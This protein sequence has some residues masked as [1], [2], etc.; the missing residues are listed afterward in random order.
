MFI[1]I[2][3]SEIAFLTKLLLYRVPE[4]SIDF[5][6]RGDDAQQASFRRTAEIS[7]AQ[8]LAKT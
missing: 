4:T 3:T 7:Y 6:G 5:L 2:F 1:K 8:Q